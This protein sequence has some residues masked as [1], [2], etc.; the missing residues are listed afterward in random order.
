MALAGGSQIR[1]LLG[2]GLHFN[3]SCDQQAI[4]AA[5]IEDFEAHGLVVCAPPLYLSSLSL[6]FHHL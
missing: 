4:K 3:H 5:L 2:N 6:S 1:D